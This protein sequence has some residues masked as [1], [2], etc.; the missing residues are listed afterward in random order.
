[1][2]EEQSFRRSFDSLEGI[3]AFTSGFFAANGVDRGLLPTVDLALEELFTNMPSF[4]LAWLRPSIFAAGL[5]TDV[6]NSSHRQNYASLGTQADLRFSVLHYYDM[7]LS[8]GYA[9]GFQ[10]GK[11]AGSEW[12]ISLKIM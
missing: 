12:M 3:F 1:M 10:S 9:R 5:W 2:T 4:H 8:A 7:T 6:A 11:R